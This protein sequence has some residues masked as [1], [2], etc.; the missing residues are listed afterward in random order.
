MWPSKKIESNSL[1]GHIFSIFHAFKLETFLYL[2]PAK[3]AD[4]WVSCHSKLHQNK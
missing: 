1:V 2:L 3:G 4:T